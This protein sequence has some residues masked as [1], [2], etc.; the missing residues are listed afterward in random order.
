MNKLSPLVVGLPR[1]GFALTSSILIHIFNQVDNKYSQKHQAIRFFCSSFGSLISKK[2]IRYFEGL[3]LGNDLIYNQNFQFLL[4]GPIWN[5]DH[6]G[7]RAYFRKYIGIRGQGDFT[8]ITSHPLDLLDQYEIVHSHGPFSDWIS[9]D[10]FRNYNRFASIRNPFGIINSACHSIN[11]LASEY[12]QKFISQQDPEKLRID[13]AYYKLSDVKFFEALAEPLKKGLLDQIKTQD[14][15]SQVKWESLISTPELEINRIINCLGLN[16][17]ENFAN[18]I[19]QKIGFKN[20]TGFHRHNYREGK[21]YIGDE[22]ESLCGE[23]VEILVGMGFAEICDQ[24]GYKLPK[25][26]PR[27]YN[28]FQKNVSKSIQTGKPL[29]PCKDRDL[30]NF[31]FNKSNINFEGFGFR[32]YEWKKHT[33]IE[34]S[35]IANKQFELDV[36]NIAESCCEILNICSQKLLLTISQE[37]STEELSSV[38][39]SYDFMLENPKKTIK[40]LI[41]I[42]R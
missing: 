42:L 8:L 4:G 18:Q 23:H 26:N 36:S 35:N 14:S 5:N 12:I 25:L 39:D 31:A 34:R 40:E 22:L 19:W 13:L 38:L 9:D 20:L 15:Y 11:A 32:Q 33:R 3:N 41:N 7:K 29:D 17:D 6:L 27:H 2:I 37:I 10:Y 30:F 1:S 21:A 24:I 16:L 28:D